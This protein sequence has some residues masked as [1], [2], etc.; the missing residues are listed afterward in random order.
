MDIARIARHPTHGRCTRGSMAR[1]LVVEDE[2]ITAADLEQK[3]TALGHEVSWVDKRED[4][5]AQ[6]PG[7]RLDLVLMDIRLRGL[8]SGVEAAEQLCEKTGVPIVFLT[9][10]SDQQTVDRACSAQPYGYL[11]KPFTDRS[12]ATVVQVAL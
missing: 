5:V 9:A 8:M 1:I 12:V 3:L 10:F 4:A 6:A 11:L 7:S 2:P